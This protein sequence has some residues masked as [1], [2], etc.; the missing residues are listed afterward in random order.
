MFLRDMKNSGWGWRF[1]VYPIIDKKQFGS[2]RD[3]LSK[4]SVDVAVHILPLCIAPNEELV[5]RLIAALASC[6]QLN[7]LGKLK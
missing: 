5:R 6:A 4:P 1:T 3:I 7:T 2:D